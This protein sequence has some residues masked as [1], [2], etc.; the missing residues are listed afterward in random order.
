MNLISV[1]NISRTQGGKPLFDGVSFGVEEGDK[2]ALIGINGSGKTTLLNL[3]AGRDVPDSGRISRTSELKVSFLTQ[4][5]VYDPAHTVLEHVFSGGG[6][7]IELI[8]RYEFLNSRVKTAY[9]HAL[10]NEIDSLTLKMNECSA[11]HF[12]GQVK[13]ILEKLSIFDLD[14]KMTEL[15]GGMLK[16]VSLAA[17]LIDEC[18]LLI[19]DEPTNHLDIGTVEWLEQYL[20]KAARALIMVTHDRYF[21]DRVCSRIIE[22]E[23]RKIIQYYGNYSYYLEKKAELINSEQVT[24]LRNKTVLRNELAWLGRGAKARSTKQ[25]A[26]VERIEKLKA[27]ALDKESEMDALTLAGRRQ[28]GKILELKNICKSYGGKTVI[29]AFNYIF[30]KS[31]RIGVIGPNGSGKTTFL[32]IISGRLASDGVGEIDT[33][34]NTVIGYFDQYSSVLDND[35]NV[36][37]FAKKSGEFIQTE[38]KKHIHVGEMLERFLFPP[39]MQYAKIA[40]LSGG[41]RR[42]LYLLHVLMQNPNFLI[43]DEPTNDL[44]IKTLSIL[45]DFLDDFKGC[46]VTV[47]H[48][49]YFMDRLAQYLFVF[50]GR[51]GIM[52][53][54]GSFSDYLE[55]QK[56]TA[57]DE[58]RNAAPA[59]EKNKPQKSAQSEKK[60]LSFGE[61]KEYETII[62]EIEKLENE[63]SELEAFFNSG[64]SSSEKLSGWTKRYEQVQ[65][66]LALKI[67][68]WEYLEDIAHN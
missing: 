67:E 27:G 60:K 17:A 65:L 51:G 32:N 63:K 46:L 28:G 66:A 37:D 48:D 53:F 68:R 33:G 41:E 11:W 50:D 59:P 1:D 52:G 16:K 4:T 39:E 29:N 45:E 15:S 44:D 64:E 12:E 57:D 38:D 19:L 21:L 49:R 58:K 9:D 30:K 3:I 24:E 43:F 2:L 55:Y 10:Q 54:A 26:R 6:T 25:K 56:Q 20:K 8:K 31:E 18:D 61:K 35:L 14:R 13:S 40:K 23:K 7:K 22:I 36:I 42:R 47:S 34:V 62:G 5:P